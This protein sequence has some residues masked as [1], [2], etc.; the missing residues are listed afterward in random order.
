M[1]GDV[2]TSFINM[3][4]LP[5]GTARSITDAVCKL[6]GDLNLDMNNRFWGLGSDGVSLM[7]VSRG[8]VSKLLKDEDHS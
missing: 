4:E 8:G 6:C 5:D 3:L 7:L 2:C 1:G